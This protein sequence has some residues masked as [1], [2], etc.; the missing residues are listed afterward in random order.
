VGSLRAVAELFPSGATHVTSARP[1]SSVGDV[2]ALRTP[3]PESET[4]LASTLKGIT[5]WILPSRDRV[6]VPDQGAVRPPKP[7][8]EFQ[9]NSM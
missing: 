6:P 8:G 9:Q 4:G 3:A 5:A 7:V 1:A 2:A